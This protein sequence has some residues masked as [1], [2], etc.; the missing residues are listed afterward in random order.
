MMVAR[1]TAYIFALIDPVFNKSVHFS[2]IRVT[3]SYKIDDKRK[4]DNST[5]L[6]INSKGLAIR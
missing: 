5:K 2:A 3:S 4:Y 6:K 1:S